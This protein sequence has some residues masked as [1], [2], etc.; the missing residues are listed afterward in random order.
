MVQY[1]PYIKY[2]NVHVQ[3]LIIFYNQWYLQY[4]WYTYMV[5]YYN[6]SITLTHIIIIWAPT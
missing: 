4:T 3:P 1:S 5:L 6:N 2:Y